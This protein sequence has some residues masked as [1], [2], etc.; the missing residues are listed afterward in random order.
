[1]FNYQIFKITQGGGT[2]NTGSSCVKINSSCILK[3]SLSHIVFWLWW[4][5]VI[6][7][8]SRMIMESPIPCEKLSKIFW[9]QIV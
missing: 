9:N 8:S 5:Q 7:S 6:T 1:M 4:V 3:S 2:L